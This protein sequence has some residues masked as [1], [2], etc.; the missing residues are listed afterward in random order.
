MSR[1]HNV[2]EP[3]LFWYNIRVLWYINFNKEGNMKKNK[4]FGRKEEI[5][6]INSDYKKVLNGYKA[7][8]FVEGC[9]GCG[10][11]AFIETI[12]EKMT[13]VGFYAKGKYKHKNQ[14]PYAAFASAFNEIAKQI[15]EAQDCEFWRGIITEA[16]GE[17][18][19]IITMMAPAFKQILDTQTV[20]QNDL[21]ICDK[22]TFH[23]IIQLFIQSLTVKGTPVILVLDDLQ[24]GDDESFQLLNYL[25]NHIKNNPVMLI[26]AY[27]HNEM[28]K[29]NPLELIKNSRNKQVTTIELG[30]L[31]FNSVKNL[32]KDSFRK[33]IQNRDEFE[34][35]IYTKT[36]GNPLY[37]TGLIR[38]IKY[39]RLFK[40]EAN[41][42]IWIWK[43]EDIE[44]WSN[45]KEVLEFLKVIY[46][47][48][49]EKEQKILKTA[50]CI[51]S[52]F[53]RNM[54]GEVF[55]HRGIKRDITALEK[56][57][58]ID[59][60]T[61]EQYCFFHDSF[62]EIV[63][64]EIG[65][66][67]N[68]QVNARIAEY[69][70]KNTNELPTDYYNIGEKAIKKQKKRLEIV[71]YNLL[72]GEKALKSVSYILA[73]RYFNIGINMLSHSDW[74]TNYKLIKALYMGKVKCEYLLGRVEATKIT[75]ELLE[76]NVKEDYEKVELII[77]KVLL[78]ASNEEHNEVINMGI[79][80]LE[81]L[82]EDIP[83]NPSEKDFVQ[84]GEKTKRL[85]EHKNIMDYGEL[86]KVNNAQIMLKTKLL[87]LI[88]TSANVINQ[89]LFMYICIKSTNLSMEY[90]NTDFSPVAYAGY[91]AYL[92]C[93]RNDCE[94]AKEFER[95][96]LEV[97]NKKRNRS[98]LCITSFV[99]ASFSSHWYSH[100][101][102][103]VNHLEKAIQSGNQSGESLFV[104]Y[105]FL[106]LCLNKYIAGAHLKEIEVLC[107]RFRTHTETYG[108]KKLNS[109]IDFFEQHLCHLG[110]CKKAKRN[111]PMLDD[112]TDIIFRY[113]YAQYNYLMGRYEEAQTLLEGVL[114][115]FKRE[116]GYLVFEECIF[117]QTLIMT[118]LYSKKQDEKQKEYRETIDENI[119]R[120]KKWG[121]NCPQNFAHKYNLLL[122][123][124][125]RIN[126]NVSHAMHYYDKGIEGAM[127][128]G[129]IQEA[130]I[131]N[132][133]TGAF[134][135]EIGR[136]KIAKMYLNEAYICYSAWGAYK[137]AKQLH[138]TY[139]DWILP[140][141]LNQ[142][143]SQL[144]KLQEKVV[145]KQKIER[146]ML[147]KEPLEKAKEFM[148]LI[149]SYSKA[150]RCFL[151]LRKADK[152][153][154]KLQKNNYTQ[155]VES[156]EYLLE[157]KLDIY[158]PIIREVSRM[159][160]SILY[161]TTK[162][163]KQLQ[164]E[165][166]V[167]NYASKM[168]WCIPLGD[169]TIN[170]GV[171]YLENR[172]KSHLITGEIVSAVDFI[173]T[174]LDYIRD[175]LQQ[176]TVRLEIS[177]AINLSKRQ[178]EILILMEGGASNNSIGETLG[179]TLNTVKAY[180]KQLFKKLKVSTRTEA[181]EK[182]RE[183]NIIL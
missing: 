60:I 37:L 44:K 101:S 155:E 153:Y 183:L 26:C 83:L 70:L 104:G 117:Y 124:K 68:R 133:L 151:I 94:S 47:N 92:A 159:E 161:A 113:L 139:S 42:N 13:K 6:K 180:A 34:K 23:V 40:K 126:G 79:D 134:Y 38:V 9:S 7:V 167:K 105:S 57:G 170:Y 85:L 64:G 80:G 115:C 110:F 162:D 55:S 103:S 168:L 48:L 75:F 81:L 179:L 14:V 35:I 122:A 45:H 66:Q 148:E 123:E 172:E 156:C 82:G 90:G 138:Q 65:L 127:K 43:K 143:Y 111:E 171:L 31:D 24:W 72:S 19:H 137:K 63:M 69:V 30:A 22:Q 52:D 157:H 135:L 93:K 18:C 77:E 100:I 53:D 33:N 2:A 76:Q 106:L 175:F 51:G 173:C 146:C 88:N 58:V 132:E 114:A 56:K 165:E 96:S 8:V 15:I 119:G 150:E 128:N 1:A 169:E 181:V 95:L 98:A 50:A 20:F 152:L 147:E 136:D 160:K 176:N 29:K 166:Y 49:T 118:A 17:K 125:E 62:H 131:A 32:L 10:K 144:E 78:Y 61:Q 28:D 86:K 5:K 3:L 87:V 16:L 149:L 107:G 158:A 71:Q 12:S 108:L 59:K 163:F 99:L 145:L 73:L 67:E 74:N 46:L 109:E 130:A 54:L 39:N 21:E 36:G 154:V 174:Q 140:I 11:T 97:A 121:N 120:F 41:S 27:R 25:I 116:I 91:A 102:K 182:A 112:Q 84:E 177:S 4:L 164:S 129:F 89:S 142:G 141:G 178:L